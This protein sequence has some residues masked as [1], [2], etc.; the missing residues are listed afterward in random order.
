MKITITDDKGAVVATI[1]ASQK[2]I[3]LAALAIQ[4][5]EKN[6]SEVLGGK[7]PRSPILELLA[8]VNSKLKP[9]EGGS[10]SYMRTRI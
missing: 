3:F 9:E 10:I 7:V 2:D 4:A 8:K 1:E 6:A 5:Q